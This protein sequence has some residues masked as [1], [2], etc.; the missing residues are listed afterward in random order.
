QGYSL[1]NGAHSSQDGSMVY[2]CDLLLGCAG[3]PDRQE[4]VG[5][6][7]VAYFPFEEGWI[8]G[9]WNYAFNDW[10][11]GI[12]ASPGL[13]NTS[14][15]WQSDLSFQVTLPKISSAGDG[16]LLVSSTQ[17]NST[18]KSLGAYP[19]NAGWTVYV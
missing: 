8:G 12:A 6:A 14:V 10:E 1:S 4:A 3:I 17:T 5:N 11:S 7:A 18:V 2:G 13:P 15:F 9:H 16:M 19:N